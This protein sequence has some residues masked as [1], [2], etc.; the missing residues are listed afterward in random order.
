[1]PPHRGIFQEPGTLPV[2]LHNFVEFVKEKE[3]SLCKRLFASL[4]SPAGGYETWRRGL[5][6][7]KKGLLLWIR[8]EF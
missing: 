2:G 5:D 1:M 7:A 6:L 4:L 3:Y 8:K